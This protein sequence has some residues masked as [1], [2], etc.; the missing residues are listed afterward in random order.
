[1]E[2]AKNGEVSPL[3]LDA[4]HFVMECAF[5]GHIYGKVRRYVRTFSRR[6]RY[7]VLGALDYMSKKIL[8]V[9]NDSYITGSEV[10]DILCKIAEEYRGQKSLSGT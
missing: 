10:Y 7:N 4:S 3:F 6:R 1:M 8:A 2:K 9:T 5:L